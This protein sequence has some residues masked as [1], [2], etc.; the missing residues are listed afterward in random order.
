ML[1][2]LSKQNLFSLS[3]SFLGANDFLYHDTHNY[4]V[5]ILIFSSSSGTTLILYQILVRIGC[6]PIFFVIFQKGFSQDASG[7][8]CCR[9][10]IVSRMGLFGIALSPFNILQFFL[11]FQSM[12]YTQK[13][14]FLWFNTPGDYQRNWSL[15]EMNNLNDTNFVI[16]FHSFFHIQPS[17]HSWF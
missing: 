12:W 15:K 13:R 5:F 3:I 16:S 8:H 17:K 6:L 11:G 9:S 14:T 7:S 2:A 1:N 10:N 4:F